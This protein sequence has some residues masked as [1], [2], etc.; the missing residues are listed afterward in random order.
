MPILFDE[1]R[2]RWAL[3]GDESVS[4]KALMRHGIEVWPDEEVWEE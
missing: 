4:G 2:R 1:K 3:Q